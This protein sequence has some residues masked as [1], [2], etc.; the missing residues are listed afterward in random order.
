MTRIMEENW[1]EKLWERSKDGIAETYRGASSV[2]RYVFAFID[3]P[4]CFFRIVH[5]V[6]CHDY[7]FG[8]SSVIQAVRLGRVCF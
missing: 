3:H 6:T 2:Y 8:N 1:K 4:L 5:S 7:H